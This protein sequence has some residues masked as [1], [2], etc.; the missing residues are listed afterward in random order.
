MPK[1]ARVLLVTPNLKGVKDGLNRI[2]PPLGLM[3]MAAVLRKGGHEVAI[4]DTALEGWGNQRQ[5]DDKTLLI[6]QSDEEIERVIASHAPDI[7]GISALFS[8]LVES[9]HHVARIAKKV[10]PGVKVVLGGN[11]ISNAVSD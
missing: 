11:H 3:I 10:N 1:T 7:I 9:A 4:H 5:I 2:Q 6:G 8:N